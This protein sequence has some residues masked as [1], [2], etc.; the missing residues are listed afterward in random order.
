MLVATLCAVAVAGLIRVVGEDVPAA[1][2]AFL[3]FVFGTLFLLPALLPL[4]RKGLPNGSLK[5]FALRAVIHTGA[6]LLSYAAIVRIPI[7]EVTAI[8]YLTPVLISLG[9]ALI[10][11]EQLAARRILAVALAFLGAVIILRP[12]LR[13]VGPGQLAQL[14]AAVF[15][16][17]SYLFVKHLNTLVNPAQVVAMLTLSIMVLIAPLAWWVWV[18][19][20]PVQLGWIALTGAAATLGHYCM[21][22]S[23]KA[24]PLG[25]VQPVVFLQLVWSVLLGVIAFG[26]PVDPFV[27]IGGSTIVAAICFLSWRESLRARRHGVGASAGI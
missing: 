9:A 10:Y 27:I 2:S 15:Y 24:A 13:E 14:A 8:G 12:G 11:G 21:T 19:V 20:T 4:L 5:L 7:A 1:Q 17:G 23:F 26:D 6:V 18:P 25:V 16:A 3:R 22:R